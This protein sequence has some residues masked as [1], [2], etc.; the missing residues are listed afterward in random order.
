MTS[1]PI[2]IALDVA[3]TGEARRIVDAVGDSTSFFK[4]G[5]ELYA[6]AGMEFVRELKR[7][8]KQVFLDMKFYDISETVK[9]AVAQVAKADVDLLTV[10]GSKEVMRAAVEGRGNSSMKLLGVSVLTSFDETDLKDLGYSCAVGELVELRVRNAREAGMDG[11]VCSPLEVARVR[12]VAG[13]E[14]LLVTPGVRSAGSD[15]ADQKR[16][17]TPADAMRDGANYMVIGRQ[18]TRSI[19]PKAEV[20]RILDEVGAIMVV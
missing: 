5:M 19:D 15:S 2:I 14:M 7:A 16:V 12:G 20:H 1:N 8:G 3:S 17:A 6:V 10:H 9:R 4:V 18:V 11:V 13:P